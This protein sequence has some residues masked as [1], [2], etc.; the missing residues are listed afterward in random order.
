MA[1]QY[2]P[3]QVQARINAMRGAGA[4]LPRDTSARLERALDDRFDDVQTHTG[5]EAD[6]LARQLS[7][8]AFTVGRDVFFRSGAFA[9]NT[10][11]GDRLL[12]HEL[13]HV[14]QQRGRSA[15]GPLRI[16]DPSDAAERHAAR[17][18]EAVAKSRP[19][20]REVLNEG[21]PQTAQAV[22]AQDLGTEP[23]M[24]PAVA[25]QD[26]GKG[27]VRSPGPNV[28]APPKESE[29]TPN[30][31]RQLRR[32]LTAHIAGHALARETYTFYE[33]IDAYLGPWGDRGYP[34]GY[35]KKYNI[36]F[37]R[38]KTLMGNPTTQRWVWRTTILLQQA[39][40]DFVINK[41]RDGSLASVDEPALRQAAFS[42][43]PSAYTAAGLEQ[44][45][46]LAPELLLT[47]VSIPEE[48][49]VKQASET[50]V[51]V[52][53]KALATLLAAAAGPAH[54]RSFSRAAAMDRRAFAARLQLS[55]YL[56]R[57]RH[58]IQADRYQSISTLDGIT[59]QLLA[60]GLP[61]HQMARI[62]GAVVH[63]A[64]QKKSELAARF[65]REI[66]ARPELSGV[67]DRAQPGWRKWLPASP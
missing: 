32:Y 55:D 25:R 3:D 2:V 27:E 56:N 23:Q 1:G 36:L 67:Y 65:A 16:S 7:A 6:S 63:T 30:R 46:L 12:G 51:M 59:R 5:R 42:S 10:D 37:T 8:E 64:N 19:A 62:A 4:P 21:D 20:A 58:D 61:D 9:P 34:I 66:E 28:I 50:A 45:A 54:T 17:V 44:V 14:Q 43:H 35:G 49:R 41:Y 39:L 47:I 13:T 57:L 29:P 38:N 33:V 15:G 18:G 60:H 53:P 11:A 22:V 26:L 52:A 24:A 40:A 48:L 31:I